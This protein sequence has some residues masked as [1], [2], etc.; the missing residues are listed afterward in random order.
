[1]SINKRSIGFKIESGPNASVNPDPNMGVV[2]S[3]EPTFKRASLKQELG[4]AAAFIMDRLV[5]PSDS[6]QD[7]AA[8]ERVVRIDEEINTGDTVQHRADGSQEFIAGGSQEIPEDMMPTLGS[9]NPKEPSSPF[10]AGSNS[11]KPHS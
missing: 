9:P 2:G 1:M 3:T 6:V 11:T 4:L 8:S 5:T 7:P 10:P